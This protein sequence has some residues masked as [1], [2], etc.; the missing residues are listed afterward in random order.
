[1]KA[2]RVLLPFDGSP[3]ALRAVELLSAY[4]G[5]QLAV[6]LLNVQSLPASVWPEGALDMALVEKALLEAGHAQLQPAAEKLARWKPAA[7]V[8]LGFPAPVITEQAAGAGLVVMG[9]RGSGVLHG[10]P[11]GSVALRV[12]HA[13]PVPT[14][15]VKPQARLPAELGRKLRVLAGIDGSEPSLRAVQA[16]VERR[17]WLGALD[18]QLVHVQ[19]PLTVLETVLP[20][21]DDV[22][23]QWSTAA[24]ETAARAARELLT[25]AGIPHHLHLTVGEA[26]AEIA[27]LAQQTKSELVVLGTRGKGAA[28]HAFVGSVALKAA[29]LSEVPVLLV[30]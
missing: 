23:G 12:A 25:R 2:S 3:A 1:M 21:H 8:R 14:I 24:G 9:T 6:S 26:P 29:A 19:Q 5:R 18:V 17:D 7:Q 16:L 10:F 27:L 15:L 22:I 30:R 11:I 28:H 20:P 13:S 4:R